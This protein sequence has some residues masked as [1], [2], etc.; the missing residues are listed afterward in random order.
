[1]SNTRFD[2]IQIFGKAVALHLQTPS[3]TVEEY[4]R[5]LQRAAWKAVE[6]KTRIYLDT[7][8][9]IHLR[10]VRLGR[11]RQPEDVEIHDRLRQLVS[12]GRVICPISFPMIAELT[13]QAD[14]TTRLATVQLMDELSGSTC[15]ISPSEVAYLEIER[16]IANVV[17]DIPS[18]PIETLIFRKPFYMHGDGPLPDFKCEANQKRALQK[19]YLDLFATF[20]IEETTEMMD[21]RGAFDAPPEPPVKEANRL[22]GRLKSKFMPIVRP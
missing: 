21:I 13:K 9:W 1:V 11:S 14:K 22:R 8:H 19:A 10:D 4:R 7:R 20:N 16:F 6:R 12:G 2:V 3:V 18:Q 17:L 5:Q 15:V